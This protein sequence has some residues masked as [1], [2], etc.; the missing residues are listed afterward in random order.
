MNVKIAE[1]CLAK[2]DFG[3]YIF[4][5][6]AYTY[7]PKMKL[8]VTYNKAILFV[9]HVMRPKRKS[10]LNVTNIINVMYYFFNTQ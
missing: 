9:I 10:T 2:L 1:T 5:L 8:V 7:N 4:F 3:K 6:Y